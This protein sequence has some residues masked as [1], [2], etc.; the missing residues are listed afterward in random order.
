MMA[1]FTQVFSFLGGGQTNC[2]EGVRV[3]VRIT[4]LILTSL[5]G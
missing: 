3:R 5:N 4:L 2:M 1:M